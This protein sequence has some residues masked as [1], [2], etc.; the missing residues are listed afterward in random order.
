MIVTNVGMG[1]GGR[2]S[3]ERAGSSQG[4]FAREQSTARRRTMLQRT[5]KPCGLDVQPF[6][7]PVENVGNA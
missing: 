5:A 7:R 6:F 4:G 3:V 2:G 1:C